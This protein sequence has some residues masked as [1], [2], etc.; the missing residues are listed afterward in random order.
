M[1]AIEFDVQHTDEVTGDF[2][3][4]LC[5]G[6]VLDPSMTFCG[7]YF[8]SACLT[9]A[10][11]VRD[12]CPTCRQNALPVRPLTL[13]EDRFYLNQLNRCWFKCPEAPLWNGCQ[14][15]GFYSAYSRHAKKCMKYVAEECFFDTLGLPWA[16]SPA[17]V[18]AKAQTIPAQDWTQEMRRARDA[19]MDEDYHA[20][21]ILPGNAELVTRGWHANQPVNLD[22]STS[23]SDDESSNPE[24]ESDDGSSNPESE[25][26]SEEDSNGSDLD[27]SG[28][29]DSEEDK[30]TGSRMVQKK[31]IRRIS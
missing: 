9:N 16:A 22:S 30:D 23:P 18:E 7:H 26:E 17:E 5:L 13:R 28:S 11:A 1:E 2:I 21:Y 19:L 25:P 3:C 24:S 27:S 12:Q 15:A 8:C 10:Q 14:W 29:D 4:G 6:I 20:K 31:K